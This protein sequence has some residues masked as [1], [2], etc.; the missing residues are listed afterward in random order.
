MVS[1]NARSLD[2]IISVNPYDYLTMSF[3]KS[4]S[5]CHTIDKRNVRGM[6]SGYSGA[7]CGGTLSYMLDGSSI[8]TYVIDKDGDPQTCGKIYRNMFHYQ[9]YTLI[10]GRIYPQGNDGATDL[11]AK[12]RGFMQDELHKLLGLVENKW[13]KNNDCY[14]WTDSLGVH[15]R[16]YECNNN[17]TVSYPN[18]HKDDHEM[19]NIGH[20][21]ICPNCGETVN[22]ESYLTH[23]VCTPHND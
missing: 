5:S 23:N 14:N 22:R 7:Y 2:F 10:Q 15:Y 4:W 13:T 8:I 6:S 1:V 19:V 12:F 18:E 17:C 16:D 3:G 21:G 20:E 9:N 11:Y